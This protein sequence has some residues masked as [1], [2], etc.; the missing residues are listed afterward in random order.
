MI[1]CVYNMRLF[2]KPNVVLA[3]AVIVNCYSYNSNSFPVYIM[4]CEKLSA[5]K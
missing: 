5:I 3:H 1:L 4:F 2:N